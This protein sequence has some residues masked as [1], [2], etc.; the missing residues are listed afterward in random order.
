[1]V[2]SSC[3]YRHRPA[4]KL[5]GWNPDRPLFAVSGVYTGMVTN[6]LLFKARSGDHA[7]FDSLT[8]PHRREL[9]VHC[10]RV[11]G[12]YHD[13]EDALQDT[14]L[15]AWQG[16]A[17]FEERASL[18]TWLYRIA[19]HR[20]LNTLRAARRRPLPWSVPSYTPPEPSQL[21]E[22]AWLEPFPDA[23]MDSLYVP[24]GPEAQYELT[25][26]ISLAFITAVQTLPPRQ[27][28]V[29][30]LRDVLGF[31]AKETA[32]MLDTSLDSANSALKRARATLRGRRFED[33]PP[34]TS[35]AEEALVTRFVQAYEAADL[36]TVVSLLTDDA[37]MAMPPVPYE[38]VGRDALAGFLGAL[39]GSRRFQLIPTRANSQPAFGLYAKLPDATVGIGLLVLGLTRGLVSTMVCFSRDMLP[40]FGLEMTL[41]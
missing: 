37:F 28:A 30:I 19:T 3:R 38:Y 15:S 34:P 29:V 33:A 35:A 36:D 11:L 12:S 4:P 2:V 26:S 17:G 27:V 10:Y 20:C 18:R 9:L 16:L 8:E 39:F 40:V 7:A 32:D 24:P 6:D 41:S 21:G 23:L 1:M 22:L 5:G 14:L 31:S 13:A 25:E